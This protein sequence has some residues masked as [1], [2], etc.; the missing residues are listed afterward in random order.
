VLAQHCCVAVLDLVTFCFWSQDQF[1]NRN[2]CCLN[3]ST[4]TVFAEVWAQELGGLVLRVWQIAN[5]AVLVFSCPVDISKPDEWAM[6][7]TELVL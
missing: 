4:F 3:A 5:L 2:L 7:A 1:L 6:L